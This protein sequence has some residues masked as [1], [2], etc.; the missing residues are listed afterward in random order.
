MKTVDSPAVLL[1]LTGA[2]LQSVG[3]PTYLSQIGYVAAAVAL[4]CG[5]L[6]FSERYSLLTWFGAA[7]IVVAIVVSVRAQRSP[8]RTE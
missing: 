2:L 1:I 3:G 8:Q 4:L 7:V 5:T 6:V